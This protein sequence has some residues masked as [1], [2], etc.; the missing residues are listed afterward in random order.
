[1]HIE[2]GQVVSDL[3]LY[4]RGELLLIKHLIDL[5]N[6]LIRWHVQLFHVLLESS[7]E[8]LDPVHSLLILEILRSIDILKDLFDEI[9]VEE[10]EF[11]LWFYVFP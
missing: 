4:K 11:D 10:S 6:Y 3:I 8:A 7:V 2:N 9:R 1:M 5:F